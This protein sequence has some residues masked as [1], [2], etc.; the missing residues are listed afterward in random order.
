MIKAVLGD[1]LDDWVDRVVPFLLRRPINPNL[2]TVVGTLVSLCAAVA[3]GLGRFGLAGILLLGGGFFDLVDGVVARRH[4]STSSFGAFLDSSLDRLVDMG[5][6]LGILMHYAVAGEPGHV[7]LAGYVLVACVMVSYTK[8]SAERLVTSFR[9]GVLER[10]E[11]IALIIAG[12]LFDLLIPALWVI[13]VGA[14]IT[15]GQRFALA[16]RELERVD[17][18]ARREVGEHP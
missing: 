11:R 8:A 4:G 6:L 12:L 9:G 17:A 2:L 16:Y 15:V 10:G 1:R 13:A 18:N 7:L 3:A 5:I 14:T